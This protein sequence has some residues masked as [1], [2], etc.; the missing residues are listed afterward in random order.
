MGLDRIDQRYLP[1]DA[2][3][4][5]QND[6]EGVNAYVIDT[7]ILTTHWEFQGRA[8]AIY[9]VF[10]G[11]DGIDCNGHG[12]HVAGT[13]GGQTFGVAKNVNLLSVRVL[14]CQ[15]TGTWSDVIGRSTS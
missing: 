8:S 3:Y 12:S 14:N 4:A 7:G 6:G 15:G 1:F 10:E 9:D 13:I 11:G 2:L 5:Y